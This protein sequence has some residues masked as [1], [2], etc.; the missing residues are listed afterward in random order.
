MSKSAIAQGTID[1]LNS[2]SRDERISAAFSAGRQI[3][4]EGLYPDT[5]D[6]VNN[7]IH[8]FFSFSPY[9]PTKAAFMART[10]GLKAAGS[11]DH[12][13][14]GAA[15]EMIEACKAFGIG[16]TVGCE[17]R[18]NFTGTF[19]EDKKLNNP[20]MSNNGYIVIHGIPHDRIDQVAEWIKPISDERNKR[21][22]LEVEKLNSIL[23]SGLLEPLDFDRD[24]YS[25]SEAAAGGSITERHILFAL[26]KRIIETVGRGPAV[27]DFVRDELGI[28][29]SA[30]AAGFLGDELNPHY[31]Y[32]LLGILKGNLVSRF[33]IEPSEAECPAASVVVDFANSIGAIPAYSYLGDVAESPTGDKK[34]E[35]FEDDF[36]DELF[37]LLKDIGFKAITY[38]PPRNTLEQLHLIQSLCDKHGFMQI[39]GVD[40]NS[41]RQVFRCPEIMMPEFMHLIDSTWALIAHEHLATA[42][43]SLAIFSS[44]GKFS[45]LSLDEKLKIYAAVG[46][47]M[48]LRNPE[49]VIELIGN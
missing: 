8:T 42:D 25:I 29:L 39:S 26:S 32:D 1:K 6:E 45:G 30:A 28:D 9:S 12:D 38:M 4:D 5:T 11:V 21:N 41:S 20:D 15:A 44:N 17:L 3:E 22:R 48:N 40:I 10:S 31:T 34:A 2:G 27:A 47:K 49:K 16:S 46:R 43:S 35:K 19:L 7:H 37:P 33:F 18:V 13:S 24:V 14:I 23:S 36:L